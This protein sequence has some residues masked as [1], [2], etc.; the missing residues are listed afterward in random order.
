MTRKVLYVSGSR[1]DYGPA[2]NTLRAIAADGRF[3]LEVLATAMHL[4][5]R[6][7]FTVDEIVAD[8]FSVATRV[9]ALPDND[10]LASMAAAIGV[11]LSGM[12]A[13]F[14]RLRPD[15]VLLLGDRS[16]QLAAAVAAAVQNIP[17]A[18]LCGGSLSG[19]IDDSF[20]HAITKFAHCHL[21]AADEHADRIV[22]MG[23]APESVHV[24][25]VPGADLGLDV[26]HTAEEVRRLYGL[27]PGDRYL[28]VIQHPVTHSQADAR[29]QISA[30]LD[31]VVDIGMPALLANPNNDPGGRAI[32]EEMNAY[33]GRHRQLRILPPPKSR[34]LFAS[35][36]A[37][38]AALVGNSSSSVAEAM[39]VALP[40]VN[41]GDRQRGREQHACWISVG[42]DRATIAAGIR[43]ALTDVDY[44]RAL[45]ALSQTLVDRDHA[46]KV[47]SALAG[48]DLGIARRPKAFFLQ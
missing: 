28:L 12:S 16:E 42:H 36:M 17:I 30:T 32:Q 47:C 14:A 8:G 6:H 24:V 33:A 25:G 10:Q 11:G 4:D 46:A 20:R 37:H 27:A 9:P 39:S 43:R 45:R 29:A 48:L 26:T 18:H 38:S 35:V 2:R 7:G 41:I 5:A 3:L 19:S 44:H 21:A 15:I 22:R 31:A 40:V 34:G 23:E 1:A 13:E